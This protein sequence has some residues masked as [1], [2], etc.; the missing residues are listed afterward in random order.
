MDGHF[1]ASQLSLF[2]TGLTVNLQWNGGW[3]VHLTPRSPPAEIS[4]PKLESDLHYIHHLGGRTYM[5]AI[6]PWFFTVGFL[7]RSVD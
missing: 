4:F 5:A 7:L 6:S 3:P 1:N 2:S